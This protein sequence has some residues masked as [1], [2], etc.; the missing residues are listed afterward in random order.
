[1]ERNV[2]VARFREDV[3]DV[4][5][6]REV[7]NV[8][9]DHIDE[10]NAGTVDPESVGDAPTNTLQ[11]SKTVW[12]TRY[13]PRTSHEVYA[14]SAISMGDGTMLNIVERA[15]YADGVTMQMIRPHELL[16]CREQSEP[17]INAG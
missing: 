17:L 5:D 8:V 15:S 1:M 11:A 16:K 14:D 6:M 3:G 7:K 4:G 2:R 12:T 10:E 13:R 9:C